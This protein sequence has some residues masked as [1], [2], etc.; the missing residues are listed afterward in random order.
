MKVKLIIAALLIASAALFAGC[1]KPQLTTTTIT[2]EK[3]DG[4]CVAGFVEDSPGKG[5]LD[6]LYTSDYAPDIQTIPG[7]SIEVAEAITSELGV[8]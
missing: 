5:T 8:C 2:D 4:M 6:I 3:P 7:V 1:S